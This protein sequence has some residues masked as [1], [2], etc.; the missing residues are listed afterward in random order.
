[1]PNEHCAKTNPELWKQFVEWWC[2]RH[3]RDPYP[4]GWTE[5]AVS[6]WKGEFYVS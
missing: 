5:E 3:G 2:C 4:L 6:V 1:M